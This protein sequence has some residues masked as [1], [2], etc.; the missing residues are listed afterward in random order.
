MGEYCPGITYKPLIDGKTKEQYTNW[1]AYDVSELACFPVTVKGYWHYNMSSNGPQYLKMTYGTTIQHSVANTQTYTESVTKSMSKGFSVEIEGEGETSSKSLSTTQSQEFASTDESIF[2]ASSTLEQ[3]WEFH[4]GIV[5]Q[6]RYEIQWGT[7]GTDYA[8]PLKFQQS[9]NVDHP[10][11]CLPGHFL[12][13][14]DPQSA[15]SSGPRLCHDAPTV[16]SAEM[17]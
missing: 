1:C 17:V 6:W 13:P 14:K 16:A 4:A 9:L 12:D 2:S 15:C 10:P 7:C 8:H 5:W 3:S 11:C